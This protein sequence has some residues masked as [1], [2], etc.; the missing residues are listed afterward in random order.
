MHPREAAARQPRS[1]RRATGRAAGARG[2]R[3]VRA[4]VRRSVLRPSSR[5]RRPGRMHP[6]TQLRA[7]P[8]PDVTSVPLSTS[9][10][11]RSS[12]GGARRIPHFPPAQRASRGRAA[13]T[14]GERCRK[15]NLVKRAAQSRVFPAPRGTTRAAPR[16]R[17]DGRV[18]PGDAVLAQRSGPPIEGAGLRE[19]GF[20]HDVGVPVELVGEALHLVLAAGGRVGPRSAMT[21][22]AREMRLSFRTSP[23]SPIAMALEDFPWPKVRPCREIEGDRCCARPACGSLPSSPRRRLSPEGGGLSSQH[24]P[25]RA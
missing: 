1:G 18:P 24:G 15:R 7:R 12:P 11:M 10:T 22:W 2:A 6:S 23:A 3:A 16:P 14:P 25:C 4:N 17:A 9:D 5:P 13:W 20:H 19:R 8:S 21:A